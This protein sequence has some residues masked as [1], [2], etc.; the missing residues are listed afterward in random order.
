MGVEIDKTDGVYTVI[1]RAA[2]L[3]MLR[4]TNAAEFA[5]DGR[6]KADSNSRQQRHSITQIDHVKD[7]SGFNAWVD[8]PETAQR[9][10]NRFSN[11]PDVQRKIDLGRHLEQTD[12]SL[13]QRMATSEQA[14]YSPHIVTRGIHL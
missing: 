5:L 3:S 11:D 9:G 13:V 1:Q 10:Q 14:Q 7:Q 8:S 12:S 6:S 4:Q 2:Q